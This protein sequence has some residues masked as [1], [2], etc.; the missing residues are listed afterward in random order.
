MNK[1][2]LMVFCIRGCSKCPI[3]KFCADESCWDWMNNHSKQT[4]K[5]Y[6]KWKAENQIDGVNNVYCDMCHSV[7]HVNKK[8]I[9]YDDYVESKVVRCRGCGAMTEVEIEP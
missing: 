6:V 2:N 4:K 8:N 1:N 9:F 3:K 7:T 5:L